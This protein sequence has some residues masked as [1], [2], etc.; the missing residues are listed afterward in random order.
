MLP[1]NAPPD[2]VTRLNREFNTLLQRPDIRARLHDIGAEV[3]R[4]SAEEFTRFSLSEINR[5]EAIVRN[6][7]APKE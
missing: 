1:A 3:G 6:S 4:G 5:H 2:I 7:G